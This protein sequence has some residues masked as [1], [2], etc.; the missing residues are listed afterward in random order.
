MIETKLRIL[1]LLT[2][3]LESPL[4]IGRIWPLAKE[5]AKAG[6]QVRIVALHSRW[7]TITERKFSKEGVAIEY[8]GQMHVRKVGNQ[9]LYYSMFGLIRVALLATWALSRAALSES[10]DIIQVCKPQPMNSIAGLLARSIRGGVLCVDCD[11][12]EAASNRFAAEWQRKVVAFFERN[13]PCIAQVVTTHTQ[14]MWDKLIAWGC[15]PKRIHYLPNGVDLERF[16]PPV[17]ATVETLRKKY[18]LEERA[19]VAFLG[20]L[21]LANHPVDLL[22]KAFT[23]L[24]KQ[25][26][27]AVLLLVGGG[28]DFPRLKALAHQSGIGQEVVFSGWVAPVEVPD[29]YALANISVDPVYDDDAARGRLPLKMFESWAM[30]VPFVTSPVG[31]RLRL[32]GDPPASLLAEKAGDAIAF[33]KA[34]QQVLND[35]ELAESLRQRG[36]LRVQDYTWD[37]LSKQVERLYMDA[38]RTA[39]ERKR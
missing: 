30:G 2:Q 15:E 38:F 10:V 26:P 9:K 11:D 18:R 37:N 14:F 19:V 31:D 25:N 1:F 12:Y 22:L 21:S 32:A 27:T 8:V 24:L 29:Y 5:L 3:D 17:P 20:T 23:I 35:P 28:D 36:Y 33:A 39:D 7:R 13:V 34:L 6:H 16:K 4:G